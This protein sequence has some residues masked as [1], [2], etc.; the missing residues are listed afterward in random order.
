MALRKGSLQF[1]RAHVRM[2]VKILPNLT[3]RF[4]IQWRKNTLN[5]SG[6]KDFRA[7]PCLQV[8]AMAAHVLTA[9]LAI[10][11]VPGPLNDDR[12]LGSPADLLAAWEQSDTSLGLGPKTPGPSSLTSQLFIYTTLSPHVPVWLW[13]IHVLSHG[14]FPLY[15]CCRPNRPDSA[16]A[17]KR[18][19]VGPMV[20]RPSLAAKG[21]S[22]N[23][24]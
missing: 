22:I 17:T 15:T 19:K 7:I 12:C 20:Q 8:A 2:R 4:W 6:K 3:G 18:R 10:A 21:T 9:L 23:Y 1:L 16:H 13:P 14:S 24:L 11:H 5:F